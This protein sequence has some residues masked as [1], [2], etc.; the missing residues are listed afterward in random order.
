MLKILIHKIALPSEQSSQ[1]YIK[2]L[3]KRIFSMIVLG[4]ESLNI[5]SDISLQALIRS[6]FDQYIPILIIQDTS[7]NFRV[8][9][10]LLKCF[11]DAKADFSYLIFEMLTTLYFTISSDNNMHKYSYLVCLLS[12]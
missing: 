10:T 2:N 12:M 6:L 1:S 3:C 9:D 7:G 11:Q 8:S 4:L 5:K